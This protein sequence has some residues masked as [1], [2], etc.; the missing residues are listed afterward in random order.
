MAVGEAIRELRKASPTTIGEFIFTC[1]FI[2]IGLVILLRP[3]GIFFIRDMN[4]ANILNQPGWLGLIALGVSPGPLFLTPFGRWALS[5]TNAQT[6]SE[7]T[8]SDLDREVEA[9]SNGERSSEAQS[10]MEQST[11]VESA[12]ENA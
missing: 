6:S 7:E 11:E 5:R 9:Q 8:R 4:P 3:S 1:I 12:E 10:A 2:L